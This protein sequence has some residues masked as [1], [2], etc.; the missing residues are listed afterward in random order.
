[1]INILFTN[2]CVFVTFIYVSGLLSQKYVVGVQSPSFI[3]KINAGLLFGIYGII[4]MYYSYPINPLLFADLRHLAI[5]VIASY[6]G[7]LP[8]LIAGI[9][10]AAGR[11]L[12]FG[13]T[14][15]S[16]IAA[17]GMF[18]IGILC[19]LISSFRCNRL[20][21]MMIMNVTGMLV[22][23]VVMMINLKSQGSVFEFFLTQLIIS[24]LGTLVIYA[25]TEYINTSN[26]LFLQMKKNSETD[27]L[28]NLN[29]LR[30]FEQLLSERFLEAHHFNERLGV[31]AVDIDHFKKI[32]DTYGHAVGDAVLQQLSRVLKD[33][34]RSFC[35]VSRTGGEEFSILVPEASPAEVS[36]LAEKIRAAVEGHSFDPGDGTRLK[37]TVSI[38]AAVHPDT[39]QASD[40]GDLLKQADRELYRAKNGGRNRIC[41]AATLSRHTRLNA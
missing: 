41:T 30:Q 7:W 39:I 1:M 12:L 3:V 19:G 13:L 24:V 23:L 16:A 9:L 4:L 11:L 8:S 21:K 40:A 38:G 25:L 5:V 32:N 27:Y 29:N 28:T 35:E 34:T 33:H 22:I 18:L 2:F 31:L 20:I 37:I 14:D 17:E 15:S 6:M 36:L 10:V 26:K